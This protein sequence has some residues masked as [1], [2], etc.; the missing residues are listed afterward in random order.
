MNPQ[1]A[2]SCDEVR[3]ATTPTMIQFPLWAGQGPHLL[4]KAEPQLA[5]TIR[6]GLVHPPP[7]VRAGRRLWKREH[8]IQAPEALGVLTDGIRAR[9]IADAPVEDRCLPSGTSQ[10]HGGA[11]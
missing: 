4:D 7:P 5:D 11:Q 3:R 8:L 10:V 2:P 9:L 1:C 6:R